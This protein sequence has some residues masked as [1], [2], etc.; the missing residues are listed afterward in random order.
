MP[1]TGPSKMSFLS[2]DTRSP[3]VVDFPAKTLARTPHC[4]RRRVATIA[5]E[6][7]RGE[8]ASAT[9]GGKMVCGA[10]AMGPRNSRFNSQSTSSPK[11]L[12]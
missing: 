5:E 12:R 1:P 6:G 2:V 8:A 3:D 9:L 10:H 4:R 7:L 11:K